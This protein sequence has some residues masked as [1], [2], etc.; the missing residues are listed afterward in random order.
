MRF[1]VGIGYETQYNRQSRWTCL[2]NKP[3]ISKWCISV[4][5]E[6]ASRPAVLENSSAKHIVRADLAFRT[7]TYAKISTEKLKVNTI[8][9]N[10]TATPI[11][12]EYTMTES[13]HNNIEFWIG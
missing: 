4:E 11:H 10:I 7:P 6:T 5:P 13:K 3:V 12:I 8:N 1:S 9:I 2:Y